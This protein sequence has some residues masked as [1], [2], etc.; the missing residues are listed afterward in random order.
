LAIV[1]D[2]IDG[3]A[4]PADDALLPAAARL[5]DDGGAAGCSSASETA[6]GVDWADG[7]VGA[8]ERAVS[9][10]SSGALSRFHQAKR[11]PDW[12]PTVPAKATATVRARTNVSLIEHPPR[13]LDCRKAL[14]RYVAGSRFAN[15]DSG[16]SFPSS[17]NL[18]CCG[19]RNRSALTRPV[20]YNGLGLDACTTSTREE[21]CA[22][23]GRIIDSRAARS[24]ALPC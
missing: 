9:D 23:Q 4:L 15:T 11:G 6:C 20:A 13:R 21:Y 5:A 3:I 14:G 19:E 10:V 17:A 8:A 1:V 2:D 16:T 18:A 24:M 12:Q 22:K 7:N